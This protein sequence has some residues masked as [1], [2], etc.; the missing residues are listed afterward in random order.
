MKTV[1]TVVEGLHR[2]TSTHALVSVDVEGFNA[3]KRNRKQQVTLQSL[4][5]EMQGLKH[6]INML[7]QL[8]TEKLGK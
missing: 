7:K 3:Y 8:L 5:N 4:N 6:E 2:D 1:R